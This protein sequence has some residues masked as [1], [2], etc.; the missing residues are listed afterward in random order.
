M[1]IG[2]V[3]ISKNAIAV[4]SNGIDV[5][6]DRRSCGNARRKKNVLDIIDR[7]IRSARYGNTTAEYIP[8]IC[9]SSDRYIEVEVIHERRITG[10]WRIGPCERKANRLRGIDHAAG[11]S[12]T[13]AR[14]RELNIL[15]HVR[16]R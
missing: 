10:S 12:N 14:I 3:S 15:I 4:E 1:L 16:E 13:V 2:R 7:A 9:V 6:R 5:D 8:F 11:D